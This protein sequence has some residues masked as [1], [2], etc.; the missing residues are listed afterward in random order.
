MELRRRFQETPARAIILLVAL[1][2][3]LAA[4]ALML[5][6]P[7]HVVTGVPGPVQHS[8]AAG[9]EPDT[10]DLDRQ[11]VYGPGGSTQHEDGILRIQP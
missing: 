9:K 2:L 6:G 8:A 1:A 5:S 7:R 3:A 10:A 4:M 11:P